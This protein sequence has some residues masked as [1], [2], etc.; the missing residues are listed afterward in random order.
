LN[1]PAFEYE[2]PAGVSDQLSTATDPVKTKLGS[3]PDMW[4]ANNRIR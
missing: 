1:I 2:L 3:N 4:S